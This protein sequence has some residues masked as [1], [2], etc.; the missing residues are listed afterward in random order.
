MR[1]T[2]KY[3]VTVCYNYYYFDRRVIATITYEKPEDCDAAF[4]NARQQK[5]QDQPLIVAPR[6][7]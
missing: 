1:I 5:I 6:L 2:S 4:R 3:H 7:R